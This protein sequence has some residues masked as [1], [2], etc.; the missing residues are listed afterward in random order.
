MGILDCGK[1][2]GFPLTRLKKDHMV[3][4]LDDLLMGQYSP[5]VE[6]NRYRLRFIPVVSPNSSQEEISRAIKYEEV[7]DSKIRQRGHY[8][9]QNQ[10]CWCDKDLQSR[11]SSTDIV[12]PSYVIEVTIK[13]WDRKKFENGTGKMNCHP[14]HMD[15]CQNTYF[16]C[17]A[18]VRKYTRLEIIAMTKE[19]VSDYYQ[20]KID[21]LEEQKEALKQ[22]LQAQ[23]CPPRS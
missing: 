20:A 21:E 15:E 3:G 2:R 12:I 8:Y 10:Y 18:S 16:R 1:V 7:S 23:T 4:N 9:R 14:I 22:Q 6:R 11:M 19:E 5:P 17:Q 13:P